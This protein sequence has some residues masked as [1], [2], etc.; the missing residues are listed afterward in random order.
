ML[1]NT[2]RV[3][4]ISC[5]L[6]APGDKYVFPVLRL[7]ASWSCL[8][9]VKG[10]FCRPHVGCQVLSEFTLELGDCFKTLDPSPS[11]AAQI[12]PN[13]EGKRDRG[14]W[15]WILSDCPCATWVF[16]FKFYLFIWLPPVFVLAWG[17]S[18]CGTRAVS[19]WHGNLSSP[20][21]FTPVSPALQGRVLTTWPPGKSQD[22]SF[23]FT[24][25]IGFYQ[26]SRGPEMT[27]ATHTFIASYV[28]GPNIM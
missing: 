26:A 6:V 21:R 10:N 25:R 4:L 20:T 13:S 15:Q 2:Q 9:S 3:S 23:L 8:V 11:G 19:P 1:Y 17:L 28:A 16:F 14:G 24:F 22:V 5:T 12:T 27:C 18:S 7:F